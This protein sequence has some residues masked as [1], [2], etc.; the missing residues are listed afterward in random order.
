[1][2]FL[3]TSFVLLPGY[4]M[5][6]R[7]NKTELFLHFRQRIPFHPS[8]MTSQL[9]NTADYVDMFVLQFAGECEVKM[10]DLR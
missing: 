9:S 6:S 3:F 1:M 2:K 4:F 8:D 10:I 7:Y 5:Q